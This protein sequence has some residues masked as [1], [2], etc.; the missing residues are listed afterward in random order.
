MA[1]YLLDATSHTVLWGHIGGFD[2]AALLVKPGDSVLLRS[3]S[4][5][6]EMDVP[7]E[8]MPDALR[9]I[10]SAELERGPGFHIL[11]GPIAV[12]GAEI[13]DMLA[14]TVD[15]IR[16]T[17]PYGFN[18]VG[19]MSGL[20]YYDYPDPETVLLPYDNERAHACLGKARIPLRPFFGI[21]GVSPPESYGKLSSVVPGPF[22][23]NMDNK[24][25]TDGTTLY[26]PV[27]RDGAYFYAG[28]GHGAQGDGEIDVTAIETSLEGEFRFGL[29]KG[30]GQAWPY[31]RRGSLLISMGFDEDLTAALKAAA[32]QMIGLLMQDFEIS[33]KEAYRLCSMAA[34][35]RITQV[36][37][38]VKGVHG[39]FDTAILESPKEK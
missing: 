28:D 15:A 17:A 21:M 3:I 9:E 33:A 22:G 12:E 19:P 23:G 16:V 29:I 24:E 30:T 6:P 35:F 36:V 38:G 32:K 27:L 11:T 5:S 4:G 20:L 10:F 31:A 14:V 26:L 18:Y 2:K 8:W 7:P 13:G 34:D 37:N 1:K 39:L 25:L